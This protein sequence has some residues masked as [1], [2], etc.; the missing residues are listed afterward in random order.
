MLLRRRCCNFGVELLDLLSEVAEVDDEEVVVVLNSH[1]AT[2][3][4]R[5]PN[6]S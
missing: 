4:S 2:I 5:V 3:I 6:G 1:G